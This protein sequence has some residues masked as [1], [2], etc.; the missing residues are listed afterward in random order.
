M[1]SHIGPLVPGATHLWCYTAHLIE[2]R[3]QFSL[4]LTGSHWVAPLVPLEFACRL[5]Y[6]YAVLVRLYVQIATFNPRPVL[7]L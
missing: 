7:H 5:I 6:L 1:N 3:L 4:N 2:N